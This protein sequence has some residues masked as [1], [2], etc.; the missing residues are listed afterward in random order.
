MGVESALT[1]LEG[2]ATDGLMVI[3]MTI[4]IVCG[5]FD[6][7]V[8]SAMA[9]CGMVAALAMKGALARSAGRAGGLGRRG[10]HRLDQWRDCYPAEN[11]SFHHHARHDEHPARY[12][13]GRHPE[14]PLT[15][16]P[17]S[18]LNLAWGTVF[19]IPLPAERSLVVRFPVVLLVV[20]M[21]AGDLLLRRLRYLRQVYFVGSNEEAARLTGIP[22][23]RVKTFAF[24]LTGILA[25][26]AGI[27]VTSR[28]NAIDANAG[29]GRR[30]A[31]DC[32]GHRG[33]SESVRRPGQ[34][35]SAR[36]SACS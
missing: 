24:L 9:V 20:A 32:R 10:R 22:T 35:S 29:I 36:F 7:S 11:Q 34:R 33:R 27:I 25:A 5:A 4:V 8:G 17:E 2:A 21:I 14:L 30:A 16:F 12:R 18:F 19:S 26:M 28:A 23:A 3:G 13:A 31:G 6:M 1:I 15:G